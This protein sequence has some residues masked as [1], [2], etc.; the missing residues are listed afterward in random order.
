MITLFKT[1]WRHGRQ[2]LLLIVTFVFM[3][4]AVVG[5][6]MEMLALGMVTKSG[7]DF[8]ALFSS[9]GGAERVESISREE[10]DRRWGEI[11]QSN[12][13]CITK[14]EAMVYLTKKKDRNPLNRFMTWMGAQ[15]DWLEHL[16]VLAVILVGIAVFKGICVF[17]QRYSQQLVMIRVSRDLRQR[18][19]EHLQ[20]LSM[21]FFNHYP[22]GGLANRVSGDALQIAQG[23][24]ASLITYVQTPFVMFTSLFFCFFVSLKLSLLMFVG[25]P[26]LIFPMLYF[27]KRVKGVAR[28]TLAGTESYT[29]LLVD[30]LSGVHTVKLFVM[31]A[32]VRGQFRDRNEK[33]ARLEEKGARYGFLA[34]P[35]LHIFSTLLLSSLIIYGLYFARLSVSEILV[36][37]GLVYLMYEPLKRL[38]DENMQ[39]QRGIAAAERMNEVLSLEPTVQDHPKAKALKGFADSIVFEKVWFRYGEEWVVRGLSFAVKRGQ[40]VA[41]VGPTGGG[42]ST[43]VHLLP[44]LYDP[45]GGEIRLDGR[46]L[47]HWTQHS[48]REQIAFVPQ[49][50]FIFMD[51]VNQ[52]IAFGRSYSE[53]EI[54]RAARRAHAAEFIESLPKGYETRLSEGGR[55]LSGGQR[56]RLAIARA[57]V[58][59]APILI[60][61][62]AT[63][64]LDAVSEGLIKQAVTELRGEVTQLIVAHRL[65]TIEHADLILYIDGGELVASGTKEEL[66][67]GCP[68]FRIMWEMMHGGAAQSA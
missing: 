60:L 42:K 53:E 54:M 2:F 35:V 33:V 23:V 37:C 30:Y 21:D 62:E 59:E 49:A 61:D 44:R 28:K 17:G 67:E 22:V 20:T 26:L 43:I 4:C 34:R 11:A 51:T 55:N 13:D 50:P 63:S 57:L 3:A 8:F 27:A 56:Q 24:Y 25:F 19:F 5:S 7:P 36:F 66:L 9:N 68:P 64:S 52:N 31:E 6:Q 12:P 10:V 45:Q 16:G 15:N 46:P 32:F 48:L 47:P 58:K 38:N 1:V 41:L 14:Q 29:S 65:S 40:V 18:Y 39:I